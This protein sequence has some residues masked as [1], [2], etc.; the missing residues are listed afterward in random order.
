MTGIP[1]KISATPCEARLAAPGAHTDEVLRKLGL[2]AEIP[3][4]RPKGIV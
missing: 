2:V 4:L 3:H 1:V